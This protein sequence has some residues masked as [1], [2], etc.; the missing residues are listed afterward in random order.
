M[1]DD[2]KTFQRFTPI[3]LSR[4]EMSQKNGI[5]KIH[6]PKFF[7][8]FSRDETRITTDPIGLHELFELDWSESSDGQLY[9]VH[10]TGIERPLPEK[11]N[12]IITSRSDKHFV[13]GL[14]LVNYITK[15][16]KVVDMIGNV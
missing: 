9:T 5:I 3:S 15:Y 11:L 4:E 14:N 12:I 1:S 8:F 7:G 16:P 13:Y 2:D 6:L 10:T